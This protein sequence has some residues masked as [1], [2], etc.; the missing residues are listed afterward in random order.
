[1]TGTFNQSA[2]QILMAVLQTRE[3][4]NELFSDLPEV[5][6]PRLL[7][8]REHGVSVGP[9]I[10]TPT[11]SDDFRLAYSIVAKCPAKFGYGNTE[12]EAIVAL[13]LANGWK[14]WNGQ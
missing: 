11:H 4:M 5:L 9:N 8:I 10:F 1:M 7:W 6:S 12:D 2:A 14:L 13:A 3:P